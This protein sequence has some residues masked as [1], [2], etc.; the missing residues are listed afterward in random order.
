M[1]EGNADGVR[2]RHSAVDLDYVTE[3]VRRSTMAAWSSPPG[4]DIRSS[5]LLIC[6]PSRLSRMQTKLQASQFERFTKPLVFQYTAGVRCRTI[7]TKSVG[8]NITLLYL[9]ITEMAKYRPMCSATLLRDT[10]SKVGSPY[11]YRPR[12]SGR[13]GG[14]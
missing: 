6:E 4:Y 8:R 10:Q 1:I 7:N 14:D 13:H 12:S 9:C 5:V 2:K 11:C 3:P